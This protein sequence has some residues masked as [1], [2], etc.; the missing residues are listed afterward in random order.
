MFDRARRV[1]LTTWLGAAAVAA[2]CSSAGGVDTS[3]PGTG[4][5]AGDSG[6][7]GSGASGGVGGAAGAATGGTGGAGGIGGAGGSAGTTAGAGGTTANGGGG[8]TTNATCLPGVAPSDDLGPLV[9]A[10]AP[11]APADAATKFGGPD[12]P[13]S[14]PVIGYPLDR[15]IVPPNIATFEIHFLPG[16]TNGLF[17]VRLQNQAIDYRFYTTCTSV[18]GGCVA[19]L[20][21]TAWQQLGQVARGAGPMK[22]TVRGVDANAP[23]GVGTSQMRVFEIAPDPIQGGIYYWNAGASEIVRYDF[24]LAQQK[25]EQYLSTG[26]TGTTCVGCHSL[27]KKGNR[28]A[29]GVSAPILPSMQMLDVATKK[30]LWGGSTSNFEAFSPDES[31][32]L[33]SDGNG[34]TLRDANTGAVKGPDPLVK[35]GTMSDFAP[36]GSS[37]VYAKAS[38]P[39]CNLIM[40]GFDMCNTGIFGGSIALLPRTGPTTWGLEKV[41]VPPGGDNN[42]YPA[43]SPDGTTILYNRSPGGMLSYLAPDASLRAVDV[44]G[45]KPVDLARANA[46]G[47]SN[48]WP[49]WAPQVTCNGDLMW[50]AFSSNRDYGLRIVNNGVDPKNQIWQIWMAGFNHKKLMAGEDPSF[51]AFWLPFQDPATGNHIPQWVE[52]VKRKPCMQDSDCVDAGIA[53]QKLV[54]KAGFCSPG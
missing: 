31:E 17:E 13:K 34:L 51:S 19:S 38:S 44:N 6:T 21:A 14:A 25:P 22:L 30:V 27:S 24:G 9:V 16:G 7:G 5:A 35:V 23:A 12:D 10:M 41:L 48:S 32:V 29:I 33:T 40:P 11:G 46:S 37:I 54:C 3:T 26:S 50:F 1:S 53:S 43:F 4:G 49:K 39:P 52:S 2:G 42:Y 8:P 45:G 28:I 15:T 47:V 36:D 18:N 20:D